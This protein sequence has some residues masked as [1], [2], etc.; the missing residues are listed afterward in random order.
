[1]RLK[2]RGWQRVQGEQ[3]VVDRSISSM[4]HRQDNVVIA[5]GTTRATPDGVSIS[6]R[7]RATC[8]PNSN[9]MFSFEL[10]E[11]DLELLQDICRR[12]DNENLFGLVPS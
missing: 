9:H 1:M 3:T 7:G 6:F 2:V 4:E 11:S 8:S 12:R 5:S 10:S